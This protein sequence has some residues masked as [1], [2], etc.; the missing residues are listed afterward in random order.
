LSKIDDISD[1]N[2]EDL[3]HFLNFEELSIMKIEDG[4]N[5]DVWKAVDNYGHDNTVL[6]ENIFDPLFFTE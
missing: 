1:D 6:D 5:K 3:V 2:I 4:K